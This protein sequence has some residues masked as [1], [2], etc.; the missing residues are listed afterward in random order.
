MPCSVHQVQSLLW[1]ENNC[2]EN[3]GDYKDVLQPEANRQANKIRF[4]VFKWTGLYLVEK[5]LPNNN[6]LV[7]KIKTD[8]TQLLHCMRSHA[9]TPNQSMPNVQTTSEE[10]KPNAEVIF[11]HDGLCARAR[12]CDYEKHIFDDDQDEHDIPNERANEYHSWHH[13]RKLPKNFS[14]R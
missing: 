14:P 4:T 13:I 3:E 6:Y 8:E 10:W 7:R 12:E 5:S 11:I 9:F 2:F 1:Q